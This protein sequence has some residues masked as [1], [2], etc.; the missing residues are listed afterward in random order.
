MGHYYLTLTIAMLNLNLK[1]FSKL[2]SIKF[3]HCDYNKNQYEQDIG[4]TF[5]AKD[6]F[7]KYPDHQVQLEAVK[8]DG[9]AIIYIENPDYQ[10]QLEAVKNNGWII[11]HIKNPNFKIVFEAL[12]TICTK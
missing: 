5:V 10:V 9:T 12:K 11:E 2:L 3:T 4:K 8:N 7:E 6:F 1:S